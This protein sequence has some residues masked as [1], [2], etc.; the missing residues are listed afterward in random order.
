MYACQKTGKG[1][2]PIDR[3]QRISR[4]SDVKRCGCRVRFAMVTRRGGQ[5]EQGD[6]DDIRELTCW[7]ERIFVERRRPIVRVLEPS[8]TGVLIYRRLLSKCQHCAF[9]L[10]GK[11]FLAD[12]GWV[13]E[14]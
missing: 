4:A 5:Q 11:G 9:R 2:D 8:N 14:N 1:A 13:H 7:G 10:V 3:E 6:R 12:I